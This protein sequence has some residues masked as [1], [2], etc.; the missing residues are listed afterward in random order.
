MTVSRRT[1]TSF[2]TFAFLLAAACSS[3][4]SAVAPISPPPSV[5]DGP[6][7]VRVHCAA[8]V[9]S[10][11]VRCGT[12][13][14][15]AASSLAAASASG[16]KTPPPASLD[17]VTHTFGG[18]GLYVNLV[19]S[20][21][22]YVG[23]TFSFYA[24]V[25]NVT[26]LSMGTAD[27]AVR[28]TAGIR[29]FFQTAPIALN[30]PGTI[31][32]L[33][34]TGTGTFLSSNQSYY[35]YGGDIG[36]VNQGELG[37]DGILSSIETSALKNWQFD[38]PATVTS[39]S[40]EV[41]VNTTTAPGVVGSVAPQVTSAAATL[42]PG[43]SAVL[44]GENFSVTPASNVVTIGGRA[45]TVT[46]ATPTALTVTVPCV[47]N[48]TQP[49]QVTTAGVRGAVHPLPLA[50]TQRTIAVGQL[51]VLPT[52]AESY[53]NELTSAAGA[54]RY[55]VTVFS[56]STS[57]A[58]NDPFQLSGD[59]GQGSVSP[60]IA[61]AAPPV[62]PKTMM[63]D[64]PLKSMSVAG[65]SEERIRDERHG[66]LLAKDAEMYKTLR[67][68]LGSAPAR[69]ASR[70]RFAGPPLTRMF[71]VAN[72]LATAPNSMCNSYYVVSA[73]LVTTSGTVAIYQDDATPG[74]F[75]SDSN[76]TMA[77]NYQKIADEYNADIEP[78]IRNNFADPLARDADTDN[79][80]LVNLLF[81]PQINTSFAGTAG[82]VATC[83]QF[84]NDD[85]STP[86]VGG[87]YIGSTGST[88]G[89][90]NF[91]EVFYGYQPVS[92]TT[93]YSG[94]TPQNWYRTIRSTIVHEVK[95]LASNSARVKNNAPSYEEGWLEEG[96]GRIAEE[97]WMR[98]A[99]DNVAWKANT[100][101]GSFANPVNLYCD[102]RPGFAECDANTRRP[103][104]IMQR[105]FTSLYTNLF[106]TNAR[107]LSPFGKTA[108]DNASYYY[109]T[110]WS[111]VR[112]AIDRYGTSDAAF[113]TA[114]T[115]STTVGA[116]N[117]TARAGVTLDQLLG[118][119]ATSFY[120]DDYPGL[121][122]PS[123]DIMMPTWNFRS[124]YAG[125]NAD[126]PA[127]YTLPYPLTPQARSFGSFLPVGVTTM[128]GGGILWYELSGTQT[129]G[130]VLRLET[131]GGGLPS[132]TLRLA[133]TRVQ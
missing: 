29:I 91:G 9:P 10:L 51:V 14:A 130:Q 75:Q 98:Q 49:V 115:Q 76:A 68:K 5:S 6:N 111:L 60:F 42:V 26:N 119:W 71:R 20:N 110:S 86:A 103:A 18:Q 54:A 35:Q 57:P 53:C 1:A 122:S 31:T 88:N 81:T 127:S 78:V 131:N 99:V 114:L 52:S 112:Y 40:F 58:A 43:T 27:G 45:A 124:I 8:D 37:A 107:L 106:S 48:G 59:L 30:G 85:L 17:G 97:I 28:D 84:T 3:D 74:V 11:T 132:S 36:G 41:Y 105:H 47:A 126:F 39:F 25:Q 69:Q 16:I 13:E 12:S 2:A 34:A 120:S 92:N 82:F 67:S 125:M 56:A 15:A 23:T 96:T 70:M 80:G 89:A 129:V 83:D 63:I 90:S 7:L 64:G 133:I 93:G 113:L 62:A 22:T 121:A 100:G 108:S 61:Q 117:L 87:P 21:V 118:G 19:S 95:H 94:N 32:I 79:D 55:M 109:A 46:A 73:H 128:R 123:A 65:A 72:I 101:Y 77:A 50:T 4:R 44:N 24:S 102:F 104:S 116:T 38:V 33:N 66:A